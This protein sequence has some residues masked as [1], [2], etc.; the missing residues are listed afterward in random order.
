M[1]EGGEI[2]REGPLQ[3]AK[4]TPLLLPVKIYWSVTGL[5]KTLSLKYMLTGSLEIGMQMF[6]Y[7]S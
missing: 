6:V 3:S 7:L 1:S 2:S 4:R 5:I